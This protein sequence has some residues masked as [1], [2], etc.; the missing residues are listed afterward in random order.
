MPLPEPV[1][2]DLRFQSDLVDEARRRIIHYC[3][4]WTDYNLSDPGITLIELFAWMTELITYRLNRVPE[5]NYIHFLNM[6]GVQRQPASSARAELTFWLSAPFPINPGEE[7]M[8]VIPRG[9]EVATQPDEA[10]EEI[11]FTTDAPLAIVS[12]VLTHL[13]REGEVTKNYYPRLGIETFYAF[14]DPPEVDDTFYIGLD[15]E[16]ALQGNVLQLSFECEETQGAGIRRSDP[17]LVWEVSVGDGQWHE[18]APSTRSGEEDTTGG[19]NNPQGRLVLYLPLAAQPDYVHGRQAYWVRCRFEPRRPEQGRYRVSPRIR[20]VEAHTLG[21]TVYA[22]HAVIVETE[23]LGESSGEPGQTFQ[24]EHAPILAPQKGET[25]EV[26][27]LREGEQ[28]FISW[29]QVQDFSV[30][31]RYDRH[32]KLDP[33]TGEIAFG[34]S[35]RQPDG[36]VRQYGRIPETGRMLRFSRYRHGGG[37]VGNVPAGKIQVM[38]FSIAYIDRVTNLTRAEGGRD[39]ER[40]EE[41]KMRARRQIR[42]QERAVTTEDYE[43]LAVSADRE[44]ARVKCRAPS[45]TSG[46]I[47]P[48]ML[49]LLVVPAA[50]DALAVGDL[51]KLQLRPDLRETLR[52]YMDQYRLLTTTLNIREPRYLGVRVTAEVVPSDYSRPETVQVRVRSLLNHFIVPLALQPNPDDAAILG[53]GWE[54]WRFGQDLYISELFSLIQHVPGVKHVLDVQV[55]YR[56]LV[57][58][59]EVAELEEVPA[60]EAAEGEGSDEEETS[61]ELTLLGDER[62]L[63]VPGDTLLCSLDH[64]IVVTYL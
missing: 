44:I 12:P 55:G 24:L 5:K 4:E 31:T 41:A 59:D 53:E 7:S 36:R 39:A 34:P 37:T 16:Q 18:V 45:Q 13:R 52:R 46:A 48:G 19:L 20:N 33:V 49:E 1:L 2:D 56:P 26:Q 35:I 22:T 54:G 29:T 40:I 27:E 10:G 32:F 63:E 60:G 64:K 8:V 58:S 57:L 11:L 51:S 61:P 38:K 21:G 15:P 17:P 28:V 9:S 14:Q 50:F 43:N 62:R 25:V 42:A 23:T 47:P 3:P 30:S 6:L